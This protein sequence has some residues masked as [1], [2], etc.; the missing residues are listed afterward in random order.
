[1]IFSSGLGP[2]PMGGRQEHGIEK[3]GFWERSH[4]ELNEWQVKESPS[5]PSPHRSA[6][7]VLWG[8]HCEREKRSA[9]VLFI[10]FVV[11]YWLIQTFGPVRGRQDRALPKLE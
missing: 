6:L 11:S 4:D 10:T 8:W 1:M 9:P 7:V 3:R 2:D 5:R